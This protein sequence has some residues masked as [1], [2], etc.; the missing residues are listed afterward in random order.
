MGDTYFRPI[1]SLAF[2]V[3]FVTCVA[4][5]QSFAQTT[6]EFQGLGDVPGSGFDSQAFGISA[7]GSTVVGQGIANDSGAA[8]TVGFRWT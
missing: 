2:V 8:R 3:T 5:S 6:N 4:F 7:D 1:R